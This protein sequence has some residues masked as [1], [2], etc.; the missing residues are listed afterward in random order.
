[1]LVK[2][3]FFNTSGN[4]KQKYYTKIVSTKCS[5]VVHAEVNI[6]IAHEKF[7][8]SIILIHLN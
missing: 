7:E 5:S 1:M 4:K 6:L 8:I 2:H 3:N